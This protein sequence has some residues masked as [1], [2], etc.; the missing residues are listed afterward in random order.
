MIPVV[1]IVGKS[2]SGKTTVIEK[3]IPEFKRRGYRVAA[4]KHAHAGVEMDIPGKDT[5][6]FTQAGSD[7]V[8]IVSSSKI[9]IFKNTT[10]EPDIH[11]IIRALGNDYDIVL[12]EGF[13]KNKIPKIEV[14][15]SEL[16]EGLA[17]S[18]SE[19]SAVITDV[20][21]RTRLPQFNVQDIEQIADFI[22][23]EIMNKANPDITIFADGRQVLMKPF[24]KE[25]IAKAILAMLGTLKN[26]GKMKSVNI[27]IRNV[28]GKSFEE[29]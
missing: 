20:E 29:L 7:V 19:L 16:G 1:A 9:T 17:C 15:R 3:L 2:Q 18:D 13:K 12:V 6:R 24:V 27:L 5:W 4:V 14:H 21:L 8:G 25:I 28:E 10:V 11:E 23:R 26:I 22:Q